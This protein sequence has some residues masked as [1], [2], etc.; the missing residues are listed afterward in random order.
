M[1]FRNH[2][3]RNTWLNKSLKSLLSEDPSTINMIR[4]PNTVKTLTAPP[5]PDLLITVMSIELE[6][7]SIID[8][9]TLR[10]VC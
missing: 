3:P 10:N 8:I 4:G 5:L 2:G 7:I 1:Y 6:K 9:Q